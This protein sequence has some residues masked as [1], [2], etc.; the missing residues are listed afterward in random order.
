MLGGGISSAYAVQGAVSLATILGVAWAWRSS[1]DHNLKAVILIVA[2]LLG[3]PHVLDYDL[4][5]L[6]PALAF[7]VASRWPNEF[8]GHDVT[9]LGFA[10]S[11]PL[12][13]RAVAG[14]TC[15]PLGLIAVTMLF[16]VAMRHV[17]RE[18]ALPSLAAG[19]VAQA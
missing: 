10:W 3:S 2:T 11:V 13:A 12:F 5:I 6:A 7:V 4:T 9:V 8:R 1:D 16:C 18:R 19:T 15:V 17:G 14:V